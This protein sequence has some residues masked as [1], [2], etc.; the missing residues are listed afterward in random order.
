ML[1]MWNHVIQKWMEWRFIQKLIMVKKYLFFSPS[2][3]HP[4]TLKWS[5]RSS[6]SFPSTTWRW[7]GMMARDGFIRW[8]DCKINCQRSSDKYEGPMYEVTTRNIQSHCWKI[9]G[10][11]SA[12]QWWS[13]HMCIFSCNLR[14]NRSSSTNK[15][16]C[17]ARSRHGSLGTGATFFIC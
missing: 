5:S 9:S 4:Q 17:S 15:S 11:S 2:T 8:D 16:W 7:P 14:M 1:G 10:A 3:S 12:D 13:M 6:N